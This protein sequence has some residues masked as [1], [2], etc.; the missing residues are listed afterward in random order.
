MNIKV[1]YTPYKIDKVFYIDSNLDVVS[2]I[3]RN[4]GDYQLQAMSP[5][6]FTTENFDFIL[7]GI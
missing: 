3:N 4:R 6:D 2:F 7:Y 1:S 5:I